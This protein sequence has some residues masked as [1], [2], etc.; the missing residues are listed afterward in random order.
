LKR[1]DLTGIAPWRWGAAVAVCAAAVALIVCQAAV[2]AFAHWMGST[3]GWYYTG[4]VR[5]FLICL[6]G[7]SLWRRRRKT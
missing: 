4:M 2:P 1:P 6:L 5:G 7:A 3:D